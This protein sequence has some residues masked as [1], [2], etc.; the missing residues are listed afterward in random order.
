MKKVKR[1]KKLKLCKYCLNERT[2]GYCKVKQRYIRHGIQACLCGSYK[3]YW[4]K[5]GVKNA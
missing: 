1:K 2:D 5:W 3:P 4:W